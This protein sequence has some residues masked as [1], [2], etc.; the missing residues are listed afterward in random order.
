MYKWNPVGV[1]ALIVSSS[2]GTVAALG[3][4]GTFLENTAAF[5]AAALA[6]ALT[7]LMAVLTKGKYYLKNEVDDIDKEDYLYEPKTKQKRTVPVRRPVTVN[8]K[9]MNK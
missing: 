3:Y 1:V 9:A 2:L 7:V 5:F 4:M 6:A 8:A